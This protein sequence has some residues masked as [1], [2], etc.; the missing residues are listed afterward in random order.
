MPI[1]ER[2]LRLFLQS[3]IFGDITAI[4]LFGE[5][6]TSLVAIQAIGHLHYGVIL[7]LLP[8]SFSALLS[9]ANEDFCHLNLTRIKKIK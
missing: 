4:E 7:L 8:E 1:I 9:F 5:F 3:S 2:T 6:F